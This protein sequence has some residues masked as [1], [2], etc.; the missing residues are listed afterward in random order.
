MAGALAVHGIATLQLAVYKAATTAD[1]PP[2]VLAALKGGE[3]AAVLMH[4]GRAGAHF[5]EL[6]Q[7]RGLT[8][9]IRRITAIVISP[10]AAGLCGEGWRNII[11]VD[12]PRR[13]AMFD[14]VHK[15]FD[16]G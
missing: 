8:E 1:F 2:H 15:V 6:M 11:T 5:Y 4:S 16:E 13:M 10:R 9:E 7:R 14:A 3:V 12:T